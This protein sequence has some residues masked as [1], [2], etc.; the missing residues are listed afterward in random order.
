MKQVLSTACVP[1]FFISSGFLFRRG[2]ERNRA[3]NGELGERKWFGH[4]MTR[5]IKM[6]AA[7]TLLTLPV[8]FII[9]NRGHPE[10]GLVMKVIYH[11]RLIFLTGSIGYLWYILAL[12][13]GVA[14]IYW[15]HIKKYDSFLLAIATLLFLWGCFY[16]S[17]FN[18]H[19]PYFEVLHVVFGSE[20]NF[21]NVGLFYLLIGFSFPHELP[22]KEGA[23]RKW[24]PLILLIVAIFIRTLEFKF[25]RTN[26]TQAFV[27][28]S[29]F[30]LALS[31][32]YAILSN[33]SIDMRKL[34]V[35]VYLLHCP[36]I[37]SFDFYLRKG[38]L[39]DFPLTLIVC[40]IVFYLLSWYAP[41]LFSILF[42]YPGR[43]KLVNNVA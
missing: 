11:L 10:Y 28:I 34:S 24:L 2:L 14:V 37:L 18:H 19:Q 40:V 32:D 13:M 26:F 30:Y 5:L 25:L 39:L 15:F 8:A 4:Y 35:G 6:Y 16:H 3:K 21:L 12:M 27:A 17:A 22:K 7:W 43:I 9:V 31:Y 41:R 1:F 33:V 20:R 38:T 29:A 36:F 42:G 23:L